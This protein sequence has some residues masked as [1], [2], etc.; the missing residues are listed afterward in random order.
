MFWQTNQV[1]LCGVCVCVCVLGVCFHVCMFVSFFMFSLVTSS[2]YRKMTW[3]LLQS[4][5]DKKND[6]PVATGAEDSGVEWATCI[7]TGTSR[8]F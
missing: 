1:Y 5:T 2:L 3:H 6:V 7:T 8:M 4:C